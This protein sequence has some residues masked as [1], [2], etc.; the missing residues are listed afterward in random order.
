[1]RVTRSFLLGLSSGLII[2]AM[3]ALVISPQQGQA[4]I[5]QDLASVPSVKQEAINPPLA[6]EK[7][8]DPLPVAEPNIPIQQDFII[9]KGASSE[10]IA[11]LLVA[12]GL[13]K[14]KKSFLESAH[15]M[16]AE[17]QFKAGTFTVSLGLTTEELIRRLLK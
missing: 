12:Q 3:L 1:M 2:S 9:P 14:D 17:S 5:P 8:A 16:G 13:I 10:K 4:V 7:Q 15:Q 11:D 6:A